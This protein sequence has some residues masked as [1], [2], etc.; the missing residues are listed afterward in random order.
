MYL[1]KAL[2]GTTALLGVGALMVADAGRA[3]ALE[4]TVSGFSRFLAAFG[5]LEDQ[6]GTANA[7]EFYFRNDTEVHV[8]ARATDDATGMRYGAT[9]EFEADTNATGNTDE[10]WIFI[11]GSWGE[12]RFGDEDGAAD[13]MKVG[14]FTVAAGTGGI[15]GAGEVANA[16]VFFDNSGDATKIIYY[17]P[18]ISGFQLG[19][20]YTPDSGHA[21]STTYPTSQDAGQRQN[22]IEAGLTYANSFDGIDIKASLVV[23]SAD[24][25]TGNDDFFAIGG[26]A[27]I[28]FA[29]FTV[30]GGYFSED[31]DLGGDR[32]IWNI[33]AGASLGPAN[34]SITYAT[35]DPDGGGA[36]PENI[37]LS[38]DMGLLPGVALQGDVSFFDNDTGGDDD[39]V[40]GVVRLHIGY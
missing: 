19:V 23:S 38:A 4:V 34:F 12:L 8:K 10:T 30:G 25:E 37:V 22:W 7:R 15:D 2:L 26:G 1:K 35:V 20:S 17:S 24:Y 32:D 31:D 33:G 16:G 11:G 36:E 3:N 13:N 5:N 14:G 21:G 40:T 29:G 39:G 9:V 18:S 28:G 6:S 27:T